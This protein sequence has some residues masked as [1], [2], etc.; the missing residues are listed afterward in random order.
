MAV[1]PDDEDCTAEAQRL[2]SLLL[3]L[4]R[5]QG[6]S[7]RALEQKAGVGPSVFRKVLS[8]QVTL[9]VRHIL[10][11]CRALG[12]DWADFFALAY[13]PDGV[14]KAD[15]FEQ[16]V[17]GLLARIGLLPPPGAGRVPAAS[18]DDQ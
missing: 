15:D 12:I 17:L 1:P 6:L 3:A 8:G 18:A 5:Q 10:L 2:S 14:T 4:T 9:Q 16:R 11:I 13:R 7:I